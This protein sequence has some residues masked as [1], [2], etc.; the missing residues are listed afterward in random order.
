MNMV[1]KSGTASLFAAARNGPEAPTTV[2]KTAFR[3]VA[4]DRYHCKP[5][6]NIAWNDC[7]RFEIVVTTN[8]HFP[9][10]LTV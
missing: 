3:D 8:L 1:F 4:R 2:V 5:R 10:L 7:G 9:L 6:R